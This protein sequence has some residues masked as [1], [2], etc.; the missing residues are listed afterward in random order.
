MARQNHRHYQPTRAATGDNTP[1]HCQQ[2]AV[3]NKKDRLAISLQVVTPT[4]W[5]VEARI[6]E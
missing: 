2:P 4:G 5:A 3:T 6:G 1:K